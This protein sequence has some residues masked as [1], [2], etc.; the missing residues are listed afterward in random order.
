MAYFEFSQANRVNE[1]E[2]ERFIEDDIEPDKDYL[3]DSSLGK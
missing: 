1:D 2:A 3:N